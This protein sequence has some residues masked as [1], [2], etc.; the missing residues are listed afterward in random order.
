MAVQLNGKNYFA[1][2]FEFQINIIRKNQHLIDVVRT[3]LLLVVQ[4]FLGL[5]VNT[6]TKG[7]FINQHK[8]AKDH[9]VYL[10]HLKNSSPADTPLALNVK[11][12]RDDGELIFN[13]IFYHKLSGCLFY[14]T[15]T[16]PNI[17]ML[18]TL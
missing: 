15:I 12:H 6:S 4:Y 9:L 8:Y 13:P 3:P 17:L 11:Y 2:E 14:L 1:W 18:L 7:L 5:E 10:A 16:H